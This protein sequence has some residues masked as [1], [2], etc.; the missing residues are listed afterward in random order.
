LGWWKVYYAIKKNNYLKV[1]S[2]LIIISSISA[3][4]LNLEG[5]NCI[6]QINTAIK[7]HYTLNKT[8][9]SQNTSPIQN[10]K[11]QEPLKNA[12][13]DKKFLTDTY[14]LRKHC[15]IVTN[16]YVYSLFGIIIGFILIA[17]WYS[18]FKGIWFN[19]SKKISK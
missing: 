19:K 3:I 9:D 18:R 8:T 15:F 4:V 10:L 14:E 16:L 5:V 12:T 1:S 6:N 2:L 11:L 7:N 13:L 17:I